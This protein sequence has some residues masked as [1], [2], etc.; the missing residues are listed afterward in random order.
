MLS[1]S[2]ARALSN[3]A[4]KKAGVEVDWISIADARELTRLGLAKRDLQGW[5]I[6]D[7]GLEAFEAQPETLDARETPEGVP[8][9]LPLRRS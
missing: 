8:E 1:P 7:A 6:T 2:L 4:R 3:L 5:T 9:T